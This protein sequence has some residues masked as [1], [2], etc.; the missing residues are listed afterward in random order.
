[1][2]LSILAILKLIQFMRLIS[3]AENAGRKIL[4]TENLSVPQ[5]DNISPNRG[6]KLQQFRG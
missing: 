6:I 1:M 5:I 3:R 4:R 2:I